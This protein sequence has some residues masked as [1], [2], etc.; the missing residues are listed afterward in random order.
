MKIP[1]TSVANIIQTLLRGET[2]TWPNRC[3]D[4][5]I[6]RFE[7]T[8][9]RHGVRTLLGH[10]LAG[11][12]DDGGAPGA[13]VESLTRSI[14]LEAMLELRRKT[15]IMQIVDLLAAEGV[16]SVLLKGTPLA[17]LYYDRPFLRSRGDTDLFIRTEDRE[18]VD[19]LF[20]RRGYQRPNAV[21]GQWVSRQTSYFRF[22]RM[23]MPHTF[24]VHWAINNSPIFSPVLTFGDCDAASIA[25][26]ALGRHAR[27]LRPDHA[28]TL[29]CMH[30]AGHMHSPYWVDGI[31]FLEGNRLIWLYDIHLLLNKMSRGELDAFARFAQRKRLKAICRDALTVTQECLGTPIPP[32]LL[33]RLEPDPV[34]EPSS[35]YLHSGGAG[36]LAA[37]FRA[38]PGA[39]S[40][41]RFL[42]ELTLPPPRY[43][44]RKYDKSHAAWLPLLYCRRN[45]EGLS[46][47]VSRLLSGRRAQL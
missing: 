39:R 40:K 18:A 3:D 8:A 1:H 31:A 32:D 9:A 24:D 38:I 41:L 19:A 21:S 47:T 11:K 28:L 27:T 43:L 17:Y 13:L 6:R 30:R 33:D 14:R 2:P 36:V 45:A 23:R 15:E 26:P 25:V 10:M 44:L 4:A 29:A 16:Q 12:Q 34:P 37:E 22:D 7:E 5:F 20:S 46:K 35:C 42:R